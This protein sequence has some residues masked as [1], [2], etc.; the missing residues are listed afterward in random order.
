MKP[1]DAPLSDAETERVSAF[2]AA[3]KT[4]EACDF[5]A[6]DGLL[7]ALIVGPELVM[8]S[9]YLPAIF[10]GELPDENAFADE[11]Q[12]NDI[13]SLIMRQSNSI[14]ASFQCEGLYLPWVLETPKAGRRV[15]QRWCEGFMRGVAL[16]QSSW[17]VLIQ[18]ESEVGAIV[19]MALLAG[20]I[21]PKWVQK[22]ASAREQTKDLQHVG[23]GL[24]RCWRY[25]KASRL[26]G[27]RAA[28]AA[29]TVRRSEPKIG[30]NDPC[31]CGSGKKYK[32]CCGKMAADTV[33]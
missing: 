29:Q 13:L 28:S 7:A 15:A 2:L 31:P 30:R 16:R 27:A 19:P 26:A 4:P 14:A 22:P 9:E 8:P 17:S 5:E 23:A 10:G 12:A 18:D 21:D 33:H 6:M 3:I 11:A 32:Q 25:F 24:I 1:L 20:Q